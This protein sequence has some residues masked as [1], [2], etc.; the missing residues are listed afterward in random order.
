MA[1]V[2]IFNEDC[3]KTMERMAEKGYKVD[4]VLT[5]PPYN[6]ARTCKTKR[7]IENYENRYDIHLDNMTPDEYGD[8]TKK[9]F[10][11][12]DKVL[13]PNGVILY[14][15]SYGSESPDSFFQAMC[16]INNNTVFQV[17][18]I[19]VWKKK[20]AMPNNVSPNKLTRITEFVFVICR[21]SE[22]KTYRANKE[23]SKVSEKTGQTFY[24]NV[25]NIIEAPNN[26]GPC[27][28][29]KATFSTEF[30]LKLLGMYATRDCSVYDP[31]MGS[32]TTGLGCE[33]FGTDKMWCFG[34]ELS[35]KQVEYANNRIEEYR[36]SVGRQ[37]SLFPELDQSTE[38]EEKQDNII[39]N[40]G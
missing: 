40:N 38:T 21:R 23:I 20:S 27:E 6:T 19:I 32:G 33:K 25:Y 34:S 8:W 16:Q 10:D 31:F 12:F 28:L 1:K 11:E 4:V 3:F 26:D 9:L 15:I 17:A 14:N 24:K 37:L 7:S 22:Y 36:N 29:N 30:V 5:S 39:N 2:K 13:A 18:D 35:E